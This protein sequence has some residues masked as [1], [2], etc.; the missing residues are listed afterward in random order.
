MYLIDE[1]NKECFYLLRKNNT[2]GPSIVFN[3]YHEKD[4][5]KITRVRRK[6]DKYILDKEG[7]LIKK[8]CWI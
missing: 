6:G 8:D 3:R 5:T 7:K 4:V 1:D 2:G